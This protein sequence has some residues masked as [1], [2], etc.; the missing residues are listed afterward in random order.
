MG[1]PGT[2]EASQRR[3]LKPRKWGRAP[4]WLLVLT[5]RSLS[6]F[7]CQGPWS[8]WLL[9]ICIFS[10]ALQWWGRCWPQQGPRELWEEAAI[11]PPV[12]WDRQAHIWERCGKGTKGT[13]CQWGLAERSPR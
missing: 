2:E 6:K 4:A 10:L 12:G 11:W 9:G 7:K 3:C 1:G 13:W 5:A 8:W